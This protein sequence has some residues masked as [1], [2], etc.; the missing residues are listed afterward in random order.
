MRGSTER[1]SAYYLDHVDENAVRVDGNEV[2]LAEVLAAKVEDDGKARLPD[3]A[4]VL[5]VDVVHFEVEEDGFAVGRRR[6]RS[7]GNRTPC[8][9]RTARS[10]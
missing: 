8:S 7:G 3:Q 10:R 1:A 2:A 4:L 5:G 6:S 9:P